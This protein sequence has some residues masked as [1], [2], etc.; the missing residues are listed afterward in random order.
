VRTL[1]G[2]GVGASEI[3][4]RL[5]IGRRSVYRILGEAAT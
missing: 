4:R 1:K 2:Q 5:S 3:A